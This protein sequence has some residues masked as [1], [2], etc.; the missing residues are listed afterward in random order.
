MKRMR[1]HQ[2]RLS[3]Q[4][5]R[6]LGLAFSR[7]LPAWRC[8]ENTNLHLHP[9]GH[10]RGQRSHQLQIRFGC[11][12]KEATAAMINLFSTVSTARVV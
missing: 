3:N 4:L 2:P 11:G 6:D 1:K 12:N 9:L 7:P 5:E 8:L 10:R